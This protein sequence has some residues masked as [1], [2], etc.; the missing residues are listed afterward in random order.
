MTAEEKLM[1]IEEQLQLHP[2]VPMRER[3]VTVH[4]TPD[5]E[6]NTFCVHPDSNPEWEFRG[7]TLDEA[8]DRA[9]VAVENWLE[10][11]IHG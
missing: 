6:E 9:V 11:K 4:T 1:W 8:I 5:D 3:A 7:R 2:E 10:V